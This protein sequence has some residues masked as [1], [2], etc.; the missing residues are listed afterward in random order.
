MPSVLQSVE[1]QFPER[2]ANIHDI[3]PHPFAHPTD[4]RFLERQEVDSTVNPLMDAP[5]QLEPG[6]QEQRRTWTCP[7]SCW[8]QPLAYGSVAAASNQPEPNDAA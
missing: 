5:Q 3:G 8:C 4:A 7:S 2:L 6:E 1:P